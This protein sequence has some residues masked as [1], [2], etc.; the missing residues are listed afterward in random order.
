MVSLFAI[1]NRA[2]LMDAEI[3]GAAFTNRFLRT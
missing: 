2:G 3:K 1:D